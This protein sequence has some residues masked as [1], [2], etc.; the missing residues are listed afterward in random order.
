[1]TALNRRAGFPAVPLLAIAAAAIAFFLYAP[2]SDGAFASFDGVV[3][4]TRAE[5]QEH[6]PATAFHPLFHALARGLASALGAA[7]VAAPG[8]VA[9]RALS[10]AGAGLAMLIVAGASG[11]GRRAAGC[12]FAAALFATRAFLVDAAVGETV[13]PGCAAALWALDRAT[14][15]PVR[16][17]GACAAL[18]V[19]LLLRADNVLIVPAFVA[20]MWGGTGGR[21]AAAVRALAAAAAATA[22]GYLA[23]WL[24]AAGGRPSV[25]EYFLP[26]SLGPWMNPAG[27]GLPGLLT[28]VDATSAALVGR[29]WPLDEPRLAWGPAWLAGLIAAAVLLRGSAPVARL[30]AATLLVAGA[31]AAFYSWFDAGNPEWAVLTLGAVAL[32]GSRAAAGEPRRSRAARV[33]GGVVLAAL[34][35]APLAAHGP[36]TLRLRE[37]RFIAAISHA[38][39]EGAGCRFL[40]MGPNVHNA[41]DFLGV[42]HVFLATLPDAPGALAAVLRELEAHRQ[43]TMIVFERWTPWMIAGSPYAMI[44]APAAKTLVDE[45]PSSEETR[46][47]RWEGYAFAVRHAP[48]AATSSR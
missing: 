44:H 19:A 16:I 1:V 18:A 25:P 15:S 4:G 37:R 26:A 6:E 12:G 33:A 13:V 38:V 40:G 46:V 43:P 14:R 39:R 35:L 10:A 17:G 2:D 28:H 32:L 5:R 23:W 41:L 29:S 30:A 22:A 45:W 42:D 47:V 31:R 24:L 20:G 27:V 21:R 36:F 11:T 3:Y 34:A 9:V 7:G 48:R 8:H